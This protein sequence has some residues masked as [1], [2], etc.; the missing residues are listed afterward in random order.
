MAFRG[1][2]GKGLQLLSCQLDYSN[3]CMDHTWGVINTIISLTLTP[4]SFVP[5]SDTFL[6]KAIPGLLIYT[7]MDPLQSL[8]C[9][10]S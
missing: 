5:L 3:A 6:S 7:S 8:K 4:K 9:L 2:P 10:V 1:Q